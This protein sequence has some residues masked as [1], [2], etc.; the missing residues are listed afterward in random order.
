MAKTAV[1]E[2]IIVVETGFEGSNAEQIQEIRYSV[3]CREQNVD[4]GL[5]QDGLDPDACHAIA[6][7]GDTCIGTG[8]ILADG[9]IGRVAVLKSYRG[10]GVGRM[11]VNNL[12][13]QAV[14]QKMTRVYLGAQIH[15]VSFY[16]SLGF[17]CYGSEYE[18][19][20][21]QHIH[22]EKLI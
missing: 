4:P 21:I 19:A 20:G 12:V 16:E 2:D 9:H 3:F 7:D 13:I 5:E 17:T 18:E 14:Q 6:Y 10:R 22:M 1:K 11:I 15:A 8:R